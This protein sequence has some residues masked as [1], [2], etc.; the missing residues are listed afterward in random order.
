MIAI[1]FWSVI[2]SNLHAKYGSSGV[3]II[4]THLKVFSEDHNYYTPKLARKFQ[5]TIFL[6]KKSLLD[7]WFC[8]PKLI[9]YYRAC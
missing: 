2:R 6:T 3:L 1:L 9:P 8:L 4:N 7:R 5:I